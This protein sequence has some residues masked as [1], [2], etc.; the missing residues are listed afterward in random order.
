M[1][2]VVTDIFWWNFSSEGFDL[3]F[4]SFLHSVVGHP[5]WV[6][7]VSFCFCLLDEAYW[8]TRP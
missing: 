2:K 1:L 6:N 3:F 5:L 8:C 4:V 7:L